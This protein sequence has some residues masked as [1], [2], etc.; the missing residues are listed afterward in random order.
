LARTKF[1]SIIDTY[2][3]ICAVCTIKVQA[4]NVVGQVV[5][6]SY[7]S[8]YSSSSAVLDY[9]TLL[10]ARLQQKNTLFCFT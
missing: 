10:I 8:K 1:D 9:K 4:K 6:C 5:D 7:A 2:L 3:I